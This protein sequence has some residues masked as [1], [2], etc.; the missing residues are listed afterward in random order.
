MQ[1]SQ[2]EE[3]I[4]TPSD[5]SLVQ[6]A[7]QRLT[8]FT[9]AFALHARVETPIIQKRTYQ[10]RPLYLFGLGALQMASCCS[11][12]SCCFY[13]LGPD[14]LVLQQEQLEILIDLHPLPLLP[15]LIIKLDVHLQL[16]E[17]KKVWLK[18]MTSNSKYKIQ[19]H[20][21]KKR[22]SHKCLNSEPHQ[23]TNFSQCYVMPELVEP[24]KPSSEKLQCNFKK[25]H[26]SDKYRLQNMTK[27]VSLASC[28]PWKGPA[29]CKI[30]FTNGF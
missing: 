3:C 14:Q 18:K 12:C 9:R 17:E 11:T 23:S 4:S 24:F 29:S 21:T 20:K 26:S 2:N 27:Y 15:L 19:D 30:Q 28:S 25:F 1:R 6:A 8:H 5:E 13:P 22:V 7:G 16:R 10:C